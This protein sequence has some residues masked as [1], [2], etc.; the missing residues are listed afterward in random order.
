MDQHPRTKQ[1]S[2]QLQQQQMLIRQ[3]QLQLQL[4]G[5]RSLCPGLRRLVQPLALQQPQRPLFLSPRQSLPRHR[6]SA[7]RTGWQR[8]EAAVSPWSSPRRPTRSWRS[9]SGHPPPR[10]LTGRPSTHAGSRAQTRASPGPWPRLQ[11]PA[12]LDPSTKAQSC[13]GPR[14]SKSC[15]WTCAG[16]AWAEAP[17]GSAEPPP[18]EALPRNE[19]TELCRSLR[20]RSR[21]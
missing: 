20:R 7:S 15:L 9:W 16:C 5:L 10:Q 14:S 4:Q 8:A 3:L 17:G 18:E 1:P 11:R 13:S 12:E 21:L 2:R 6:A 19:V